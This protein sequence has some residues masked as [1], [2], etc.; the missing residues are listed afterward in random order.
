MSGMA[1]S[2]AVRTNPPDDAALAQTLGKTKNVWD[3]IVD[4]IDRLPNGLVRKWKFY[5]TK[6]GW[7]MKVT[8]GKRAVLYLVPHEGTFLAALALNDKAVAALRSQKIPPRLL[9]EITTG[10][11]YPEGRPARIEVTSRRDL[12]V[13]KKLLALKLGM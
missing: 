1:T 3:A 10:K 11:T 8:D 6:Y 4:H 12:A 2:A 9:R 7:Q 5:G 13:V